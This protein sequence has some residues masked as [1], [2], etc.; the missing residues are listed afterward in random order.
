MK[1]ILAIYFSQPKVLDY[2][3]NKKVYFESYAEL[4]EYWEKSGIQTVIVRADTYLSKGKFSHYSIWNKQKNTYEKI[5]KEII[6]DLIWNKDSENT[7]PRITDC[8]ILNHPDFDEICRDKFRS[9]AIRLN[10]GG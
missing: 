8:P 4:I 3:L 10:F 5:N 2:P 6:V 7:I 1:K 9:Y